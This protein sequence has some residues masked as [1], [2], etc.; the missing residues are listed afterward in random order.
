MN[1]KTMALYQ[2][3]PGK[4]KYRYGVLDVG[5]PT[6]TIEVFIANMV[7]LSNAIKATSRTD[8]KLIRLPKAFTSDKKLKKYIEKQIKKGIYVDVYKVV[9]TIPEESKSGT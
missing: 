9:S 5:E 2:K 3:W 1:E 8:A 6:L 7:G 4:H